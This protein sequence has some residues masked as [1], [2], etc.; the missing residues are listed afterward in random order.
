MVAFAA[1][2][3][4]LIVSKR[5]QPLETA[6]NT[7]IAQFCRDEVRIV[8]AAIHILHDSTCGGRRRNQAG[9]RASNT[10]ENYSR[11]SLVGIEYSKDATTLRGCLLARLLAWVVGMLVDS[12]VCRRNGRRKAGFDKIGDM[13]SINGKSDTRYAASSRE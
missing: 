9:T 12:E 11:T 13:R 7:L 8:A 5:P 4:A 10:D 2:S 3:Q 6:Y 1:D